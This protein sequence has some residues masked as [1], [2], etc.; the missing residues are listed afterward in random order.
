MNPYRYI[1][2]NLPLFSYSE[3][4][5]SVAT[6][7]TVPR[8][9]FFKYDGT[10]MYLCGH[11]NKRIYQYTLS[12]PWDISTAGYDSV[13]KNIS[14]E[15]T[16]PAG[17]WFSPD[18]AKMYLVGAAGAKIYQYSLSTPWSL[19]TLSYDSVS[20][21][22]SSED[23]SPSGIYMRR[24]G[25]KLYVTG[26]DAELIIEYTLSTA[27]NLATAS[28]SQNIDVSGVLTS[29]S[30]VFFAPNGKR[31]FVL[32]SVENL[33]HQYKLSTAWDISTASYNSIYLDMSSEDTSCRGLFISPNGKNIFMSGTDQDKV[34]Q[35]KC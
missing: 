16:G 11:G 31:M 1:S 8:D 18:G 23:S 27:W 22:T 33:L 24:D 15:E 26:R 12:T 4:S 3:L 17:V 32:G 21:S 30:N 28:Y 34:F 25:L 35:Y 5:K 20:K 19:S 14:S 6:V 10:K 7:D 29:V 9:V 13:Y 2:W